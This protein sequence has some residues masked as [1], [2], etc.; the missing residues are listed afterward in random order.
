MTTSHGMCDSVG[1]SFA[2][3]ARPI[4]IS[5]PWKCALVKEII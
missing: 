2:H 3:L 1:L 5:D 4:R